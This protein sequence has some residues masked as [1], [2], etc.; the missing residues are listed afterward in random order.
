[1]SFQ[2]APRPLLICLL[3][4]F[5]APA[6]AA[7]AIVAVATNF[8]EA[9]RQLESAFEEANDHKLT[10][11][12]GSTG[13][14]YAQVM[15]GA[16]FDALLAAD[17]ERPE[18]LESS[19]MGVSGTRFTYATGVLVLWSPDTLRIAADGPAALR[20]GRF[21]AL[22]I[23]NPNLAPYGAASK[24][25]LEALGLW[26]ALVQ[27]VVLGE[28]VGQA[29]AY[30][31]TRNAQLGFVAKSQVLSRRNKGVSVGWEV[32]ADLHSPIRQDAVLLAHGKDND[33]AIAFLAYLR[34]AV[35]Q[36]VIASFGY[37]VD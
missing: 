19:Q 24:Q 31:A 9:A 37:K 30:V 36:N 29:F 13:K 15:Q 3:A 27:K 17:Q 1:M 14:L 23:A 20:S 6:S 8:A 32:P 11:T 5:C 33:A 18:L 16:P 10:I 22:A 25:T 34:S 2:G 12:T 7:E 21:K 26:E 35:A 4:F 28:N